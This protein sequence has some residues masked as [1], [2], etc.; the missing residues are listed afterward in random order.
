MI[1]IK[2]RVAFYITEQREETGSEDWEE[3][4]NSIVRNLP[5]ENKKR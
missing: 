3:E 4:M 1:S 5:R 2:I